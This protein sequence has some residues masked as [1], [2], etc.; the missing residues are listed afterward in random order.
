MSRY[1]EEYTLTE[2]MAATMAREFR[3]QETAF[4]GIGPPLIAAM[5]AN[6]THAP[7]MTIAV[8]GGAVGSAPRRLLTCIADS[9]IDE[10]AYSCIPMWRLFGDQQRGFYDVGLIGAAQIDKYGNLNTTGIGGYPRS[11]VRV[12]GSGGGNDIGSSAGRLLVMMRQEKRRFIDRVD[13]LTTPGFLDGGDSRLKAG[14]R[15]DGPSGVITDMGVF[16]FAPDSKEMY[17]EKCHPGV[18]PEQVQASVS[19]DLKIAPQP[20]ATEP[21]TTEQVEIMRTLDPFGLYLGNGR[22]AMADPEKGFAFYMRV[23]EESYPAMEKLLRSK[24]GQ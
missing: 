8:E 5:L 12:A 24:G 1:A 15:G 23:L 20:A 6:L 18:R 7:D 4:V 10:R 14:L 19:W 16:R 17:L 2:L 13:Y 21:P 22:A 9:T 3:N 11:K